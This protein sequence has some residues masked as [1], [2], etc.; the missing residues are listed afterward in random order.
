MPNTKIS[1]LDAPHLAAAAHDF[2]QAEEAFNQAQD[3]RRRA[4]A[5]DC[6]F[7]QAPCFVLHRLPLGQ[8]LA[9]I[10]MEHPQVG[11]YGFPE[12][13]I[14]DAR[15]VQFLDQHTIYLRSHLPREELMEAILLGLFLPP[16][17]EFEM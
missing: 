9:R 10:P 12:G 14:P 8:W 16:E 7:C 6:A 3:A 5:L 11:G 2:S 17:Y 15:D 13:R 1:E 4:Q